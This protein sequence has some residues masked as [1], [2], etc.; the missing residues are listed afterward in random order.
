MHSDIFPA[1]H[2]SNWETV[3]ILEE[4]LG[5]T[6]TVPAETESEPL[7]KKGKYEVRVPCRC[8]L[9]QDKVS[10]KKSLVTPVW[11]MSLLILPGCWQ[12]WHPSQTYAPGGA[13][14]SR[15]GV[16]WL[17]QSLCL[18][19]HRRPETKSRLQS[20]NQKTWSSFQ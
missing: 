16:A 3:F 12:H 20:A 18:E 13:V 4:L 15:L 19:L 5:D 14:L 2:Y 9:E 10:Y 8:F 7:E 1:R 6:V 17:T 11:R